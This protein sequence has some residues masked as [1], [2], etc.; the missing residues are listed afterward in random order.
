MARAAAT[1]Q[2]HTETLTAVIEAQI[3]CCRSILE[4]TEAA[5]AALDPLDLGALDRAV[6]GRARALARLSEL[7]AEA[8]G[9]RGRVFAPPA[10]LAGH[11][12]LL[13]D[14]TRRILR[15][16]ARAREATERAAGRLKKKIQGMNEGQR[17]LK[18]YRGP[19]DPFPRF[20][21]RRG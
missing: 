4:A 6:V 17:C 11:L 15:A 20:A 9:L 18:G 8:E 14:L 21:D 3:A 7:E 5:E 10:G 13:Q 2:T 19:A 16:D 1:P 12:A